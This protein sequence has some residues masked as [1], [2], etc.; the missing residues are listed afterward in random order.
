MS[1]RFIASS[2]FCMLSL[3]FPACGGSQPSAE[4]PPAATAEASNN[5]L[6]A[7]S[8]TPASEAV[9]PAPPAKKIEATLQPKSKSKVTGTATLTETTNGVSVVLVLE[10]LTPGDHGAHVHEKGDCS[11]ED[12]SS[13]G[14]HFNPGSH[15]HA[16]PSGAPRHLGD[17]GNI[18]A[19]KDG[20]AKLEIIAVGANLKDSDPSSFVG[21]SIVIHEKKDDGGQPTGNAGGRVACAEIKP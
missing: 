17:L 14:G 18:S 9:S 8:S 13:A 10:N 6:P 19:D 3:L 16:L 2:S 15:P 4:S 1:H 5:A 11:A 12:A 20:K 7:D 21:K